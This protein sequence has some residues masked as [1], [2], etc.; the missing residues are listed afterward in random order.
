MQVSSLIIRSE[1]LIILG[2]GG[3]WLSQISLPRR[4][5]SHGNKMV[6]SDSCP[7]DFGL[8]ALLYAGWEIN[9]FGI[10]PMGTGVAMY[11]GLNWSVDY[12]HVHDAILE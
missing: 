4:F 7:P 6:G 11:Q 2:G 9:L 12:T 1:P 3:G 8:A 5:S 10:L